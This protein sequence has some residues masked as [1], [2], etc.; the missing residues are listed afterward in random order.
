MDLLAVVHIEAA[1]GGAL[2]LGTADG[3]AVELVPAPAAATA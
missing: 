2:R 1:A 3:P